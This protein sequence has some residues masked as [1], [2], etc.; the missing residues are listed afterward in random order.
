MESLRETLQSGRK[1]KRESPWERAKNWSPTP[2]G[3]VPGASLEKL[4]LGVP[5]I[6]RGV[7]VSSGVVDV[8]ARAFDSTRV[9]DYPTRDETSFEEEEEEEEEDEEDADQA[10]VDDDDDDDEDGRDVSATI[11]VAGARVELS[12]SQRASVAASVAC[13]L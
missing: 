1:R 9:D 3:V 13:L 2:I 4:V 10:R 6:A 5:T 8:D 11:N 12:K 7:R